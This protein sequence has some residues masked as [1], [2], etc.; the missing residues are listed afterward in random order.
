MKTIRV[1][2]R[3]GC[4]L[5]EK[6]IESLLPLIRGRLELDIVDIDSQPALQEDYGTRIPLVEFDGRIVCQYSLDESAIATIL[7]NQAGS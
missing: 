3:P 1:Y 7:A 5:C 6:L 4:H 2:S